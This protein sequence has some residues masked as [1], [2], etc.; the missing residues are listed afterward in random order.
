MSGGSE[1]VFENTVEN[2][3]HEVLEGDEY[4]EKAEAYVQRFLES[5]SECRGS[6]EA[7]FGEEAILYQLETQ[8][9]IMVTYGN[10]SVSLF[11]DQK[12]VDQSKDVLT[13]EMPGLEYLKKRASVEAEYTSQVL[14]NFSGLF[15]E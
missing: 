13:A 9:N 11:G 6:K 8:R 1:D 14:K 5:V 3:T 10:S 7:R 12:T 15:Q 4:T 2:G